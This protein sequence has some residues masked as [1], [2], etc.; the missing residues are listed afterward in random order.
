MEKELEKVVG[1]DGDAPKEV[2]L[3]EAEQVLGDDSL[4]QAL[5]VQ[6]SRAYVCESQKQQGANQA[7][8][9]KRLD[10]EVAQYSIKKTYGKLLEMI[11]KAFRKERPLFSLAIYYP[12]HYYKGPDSSIDPLLE[13]R[14]KQVVGLIRTQFLKRFESSAE[15]FRCSCERL[16]LKLLAFVT[17]H[18]DSPAEVKRLNRWCA[19]HDTLLGYVCA[20][21]KDLFGGEAEE[22]DADEDIVPPELLEQVEQLDPAQYRVGEM[23]DETYLDLD[24]VAEFLREL[25]KFKSAHDD[26][27]NALAKL[28]KSDPVLKKHKVLIFTEFADT[29]QY[30]CRELKDRGA[31]VWPFFSTWTRK[32][33]LIGGVC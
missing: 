20:H 24:Q 22:E 7:L 13:N 15:A 29:A 26:K 30:L 25:E 3:N 21:Q 9:P 11:E 27:L 5:V 12:L 31:R 33:P 4:F 23:L 19:Q 8:F 32:S 28:L 18:S 16:L 6:R 17:R 14:Q 10:P 2:S 1:G